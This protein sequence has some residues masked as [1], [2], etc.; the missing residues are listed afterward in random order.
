MKN[1]VSSNTSF[2]MFLRN[3]IQ[4]TYKHIKEEKHCLKSKNKL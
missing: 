1:R 2:Y 4:K 3:F